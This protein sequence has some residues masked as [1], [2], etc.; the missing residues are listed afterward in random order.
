MQIVHFPPLS[1]F[2][3]PI[4]IIYASLPHIS[5]LLPL[6]SLASRFLC[7]HRLLTSS[8][9]L[10]TRSALSALFATNPTKN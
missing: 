8:C 9:P 10:C 7:P 4:P 6:S 1:L 2:P 3:H 5:F